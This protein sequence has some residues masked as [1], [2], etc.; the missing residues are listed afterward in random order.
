MCRSQR[1]QRRYPAVEHL[2]Q[3]LSWAAVGFVLGLVLTS[4][5]IEIIYHFD[6]TKLFC[7]SGPD[8]QQGESIALLL[9]GVFWTDAI[10][11]DSYLPDEK[12]FNVSASID[13]HHLDDELGLR[14]SVPERRPP[15]GWQLSG[16]T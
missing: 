4:C 7:E 8:G 12:D 10:G 11:Y 3:R 9:V 15:I 6:F 5:L 13:L 14:A 1:D 16:F 2:L